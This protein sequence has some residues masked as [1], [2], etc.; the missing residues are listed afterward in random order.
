MVTD[1][2]LSQA[3]QCL[4]RDSASPTN[5]NPFSSLNAV[6]QELQTK[7]GLDL[8]HKLDFIH[9]QIQFILRSHPQQPHHHQHHHHHHHQQQQQQQLP[10]SQKDLFALHQSPNFQSAPSPTS[11]AFHTFSAQPPPAKPDSVV[12]PTVPGSDPPKERWGS[13]GFFNFGVLGFFYFF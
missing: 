6:V 10:S 4:L 3:I 7:L 11:S 1:Q 13:F 12:A 2:E 8:S 5:P 9:A